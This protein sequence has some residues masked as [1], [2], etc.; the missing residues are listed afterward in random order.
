MTYRESIISKER[1]CASESNAPFP[2]IT[3]RGVALSAGDLYLHIYG[4]DPVIII[5]NNMV[6]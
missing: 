1:S 2:F 4:S 5:L 3:A 6:M